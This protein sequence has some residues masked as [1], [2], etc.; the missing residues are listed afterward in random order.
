MPAAMKYCHYQLACIRTAVR[1]QSLKFSADMTIGC[2]LVATSDRPTPV[3]LLRKSSVRF[4]AN[5]CFGVEQPV[6]HALY[7]TRA[8]HGTM[9]KQNAPGKL[10]G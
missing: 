4:L 6:W 3:L 1:S 7:F 9:L 10:G 5:P 8:D 2:L